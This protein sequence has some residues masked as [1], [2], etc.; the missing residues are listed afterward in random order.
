MASLGVLSPQGAVEQLLR[1]RFP[2]RRLPTAAVHGDGDGGENK[3]LLLFAVVLRQ[4][5]RGSLTG[6]SP[7]KPRTG[8][9]YSARGTYAYHTYA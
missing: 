1:A 2:R 6:G 9:L 3:G 5:M 7:W 4:K 8:I